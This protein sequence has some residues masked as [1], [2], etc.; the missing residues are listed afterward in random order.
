[1]AT[2]IASAVV[3]A[4]LAFAYGFIV[5][6]AKNYKKT[7]SFRPRALFRTVVVGV[8]VGVYAALHGVT[9]VAGVQ[10]I[11]PLA[12]PIGDQIVKVLWHY[13]GLNTV[14]AGMGVGANGSSGSGNG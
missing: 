4:A 11:L 9:S 5:F 3:Y 6:L 2:T 12:I 1:M 7:E 10:G 8:V 13:F 14:L